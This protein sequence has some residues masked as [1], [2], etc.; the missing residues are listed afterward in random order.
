MIM[1]QILQIAAIAAATLGTGAATLSVMNEDIPDLVVPAG[2]WGATGAL[3]GMSFEI[4]ARIW[5]LAPS[6]RTT[7]PSVMAPSS[8]LI[9]RNTATSAGPTIRPGKSMA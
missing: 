4:R 8:R 3:D 1:S 7:S 9:A 6:W 5:P 2:D